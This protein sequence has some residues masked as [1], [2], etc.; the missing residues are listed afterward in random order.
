MSYHYLTHHIV[1]GPQNLSYFVPLLLLP[2]ALLIPRTVLSRWQSIAV[3]LPIMLL[4]TIHAWSRMRSV[5]VISVDVLLQALMLLALKDPWH[6][7]KLVEHGDL[8]VATTP[9]GSDKTDIDKGTTTDEQTPLAKSDDAHTRP[10]EQRYPNILSERLPWVLKLLVSLRLNNWKIGRRGHDESQPP[11]RC[12]KTRRAFVTQS[13][14]SCLRGFLLL[15]LTRAYISCDPYFTDLELSISSPLPFSW[16]NWLPSQILRSMII[17][18]QAW[19]L[20]SQMFYLP[21]LLPVGLNALGILPDE[22]SPH[23]WVPYFGPAKHIFLSGVRGFWGQYWHQTMRFLTSEPGYAIANGLKMKSGGLS[24]YAIITIVAF[25]LSGT[26]HSGL[27]PPELLH[28]TVSV[29]SIRLCV[30][31]FF[32]VQPLAMMV[33]V[34]ITRTLRWSSASQFRRRGSQPIFIGIINAIWLVAWFSTCLPLLGEAGRQLGYWTVWP[35]PVSLWKG[36]RGEGWVVWPCLFE[37]LHNS[38]TLPVQ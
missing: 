1:P 16:L 29:D 32:W 30:A 37:L 31:G 35:L 3:F 13:L 6:E 27:V 17:G 34:M 28:A 25:G 15:D 11:A 7:F 12:F 24:R 4:S 26:I 8:A 5:D 22:W 14:I 38:T 18:A 21:C 33:E 20:V 9:S 36:I 19:A 2:I 23:T 10:R